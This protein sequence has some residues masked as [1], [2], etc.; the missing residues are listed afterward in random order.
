M[1]LSFFARASRWQ[2]ARF[3]MAI[4]SAAAISPGLLGFAG[5]DCDSAD[6]V[7][8]RSRLMAV[9][10]S[11]DRGTESSILLDC[12][13]EQYRLCSLH[14]QQHFELFTVR[15]DCHAADDDSMPVGGGGLVGGR[16]DN[17]A[18]RSVC[19]CRRSMRVHRAGNC[20]RGEQCNHCGRRDEFDI[21]RYHLVYLANPSRS[22]REIT[23]ILLCTRQRFLTLNCSAVLTGCWNIASPTTGQWPRDMHSGVAE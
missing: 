14:R 15:I 19:G 20:Y 7:P 12:R 6:V 21:A 23:K 8:D 4:R 22:E 10:M 11:R 13:H 1:K 16:S 18:S 3:S 5:A 2:T 17:F 9:K